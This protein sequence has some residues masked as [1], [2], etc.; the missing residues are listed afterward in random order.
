MKTNLL[1]L[2]A[3]SIIMVACTEPLSPDPVEEG[4]PSDQTVELTE[5]QKIV[6]A[7]NGGEYGITLKYTD[8]QYSLH[9][10]VSLLSSDIKSTLE[11]KNWDFKGIGYVRPAGVTLAYFYGGGLNMQFNDN[12]AHVVIIPDNPSEANIEKESTVVFGDN[13]ITVGGFPFIVCSISEKVFYCV[14]DV[15]GYNNVE[16]YWEYFQC[17]VIEEPAE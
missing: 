1:I 11:G 4:T 16:N 2:S 5:E 7:F 9:P 14:A 13:L 10:I 17:S 8:G 12:T 6:E 15:S 3:I